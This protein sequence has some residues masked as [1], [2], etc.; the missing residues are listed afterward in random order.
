VKWYVIRLHFAI[1]FAHPTSAGSAYVSGLANGW[2][3]AQIKF[4]RKGSRATS[5]IAW[6]SLDLIRGEIERQSRSRRI[7][8]DYRNYLP[9]RGVR[10]GANRLTFRLERF[11]KLKV[12][13]F[14][15]FSDSGILVTRH[16]P[17]MLTLRGETTSHRL[18][19]GEPFELKYLVRNQ[20]DRDARDVIVGVEVPTTTPLRILGEATEEFRRVRRR[21]QGT[22]RLKAR[23]AGRFP[24]R[25]FATGSANSTVAPVNVRVVPEPQ[26]A[27]SWNLTRVLLGAVLVVSG[28]VVMIHRGG[29]VRKRSPH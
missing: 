24:I 10:P 4:W 19:P 5:P 22:F 15:V 14:R 8:I 27:S 3:G 7:E 20:G 21:A 1:A 26:P 28:V 18:A 12:K 2:A 25:L 16:S 13:Q 9:Y 17:P 23:R 29:G 6:N 11:G